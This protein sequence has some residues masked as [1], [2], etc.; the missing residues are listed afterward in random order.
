MHLQSRNKHNLTTYA[1]SVYVISA[2]YDNDLY[3]TLTCYL[4]MCWGMDFCSD[5]HHAWWRIRGHEFRII[6]QEYAIVHTHY[7]RCSARLVVIGRTTPVE[8]V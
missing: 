1:L 3:L 8:P 7:L 4:V 6:T 2:T 5:I